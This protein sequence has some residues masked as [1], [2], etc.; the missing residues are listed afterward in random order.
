[1]QEAA[2]SGA[3]RDDL[4]Y[5][6]AVVEIRIPALRE[7]REDIPVLAEHFLRIISE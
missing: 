2:E 5:R 4:F 1:L 6:L 3:F 7:R